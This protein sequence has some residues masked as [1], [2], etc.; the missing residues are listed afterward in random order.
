MVEH[1]PITNHEVRDTAALASAGCPG[2]V[3]APLI[4]RSFH[5]ANYI[6][7]RYNLR[8]PKMTHMVGFFHVS[9]HCWSTMKDSARRYSVP[10]TTIARSILELTVRDHSAMAARIVA[11]AVNGAPLSSAFTVDLL[12]GAP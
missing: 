9:E 8:P 10:V 3:I 7:R 6:R 11:P 5:S 2:K 1:R 12:A 4:D